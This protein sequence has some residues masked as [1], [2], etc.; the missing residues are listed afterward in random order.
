MLGGMPGKL[1]YLFGL[2]GLVP[3]L[4]RARGVRAHLVALWL[5][6]HVIARDD[7]Y[8]AGVSELRLRLTESQLAEFR[9]ALR[10]PVPAGR[11]LGVRNA[12]G[13]QSGAM[14]FREGSDVRN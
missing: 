2:S 7:E 14:G 6:S 10:G 1:S 8:W 13:A 9:P 4:D 12:A 11:N 5:P 3:A